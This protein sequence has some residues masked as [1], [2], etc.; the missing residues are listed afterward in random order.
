LQNNIVNSS[1][2]LVSCKA[3]AQ[4]VILSNYPVDKVN[5]SANIAFQLEEQAIMY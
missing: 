2:V 4:H 3:N 5:S 1:L